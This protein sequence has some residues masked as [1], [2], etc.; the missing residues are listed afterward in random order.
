MD[1]LHLYKLVYLCYTSF[2]K[3]GVFMKKLEEITLKV[4]SF[5]SAGTVDGPGIRFVVFT[6]G[7]PLRCQY[8]HNPDTWKLAGGKTYTG[9]EIV[10]EVLKYK[11]FM[12]FSKGGVTFSGG[13]PLVQKESLIPILKALKEEGIHTAIDTAGTTQIDAITEELLEYVDLVLLDIKHIDKMA[14]KELTGMTNEKCFS[15]LNLL[16]KKQIRTWVRWVIVPS[17]NDTE[18]YAHQFAERLKGYDNIELVELLPYHKAGVYKW[19]ELGLA[20]PLENVKEPDKE[21]VEEL[22][23]V[24]ESSFI[25]TL[26]SGKK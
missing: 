5:E 15:F 8:C 6:Q 3:V 21:L 9:A 24:L 26:Y 13:E 10:K 25:K 14:H 23:S 2:Q 18:S 11:S 1:V 22:S 19:K 16:K 20:Y 12:T 17:L 7:C 4:H